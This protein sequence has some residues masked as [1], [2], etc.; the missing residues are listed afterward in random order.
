MNDAR[1]FFGN[2]ATHLQAGAQN[3]VERII[4]IDIQLLLGLSLDVL[5]A[6]AVFLVGSEYPRKPGTVHVPVDHLGRCPD[7]GQQP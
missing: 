7:V 5:A 4:G 6:L 3:A 1:L 2:N